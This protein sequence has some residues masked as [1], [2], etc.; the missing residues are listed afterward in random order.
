MTEINLL[1]SIDDRYVEQFKTTL[2]SVYL[3]T[4]STLLHVFVL[5]KQLLEKNAEIEDF[6]AALGIIYEPVVIGEKLLKMLQVL[7]GIQKQ[8]TIACWHMNTFLKIWIGFFIW[9]QIF[10]V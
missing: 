9:M 7:I 3:N 5:Q 8:S 6:C 1:F 10:Y 4:P 2:Y